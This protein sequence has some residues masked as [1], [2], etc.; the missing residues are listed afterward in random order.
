L[1]RIRLLVLSCISAGLLVASVLPAHATTTWNRNLNVPATA[2]VDVDATACTNHPGP[3]IN[4]SGSLRLGGVSVVLKLDNNRNKPGIFEIQTQPIESSVVVTNLTK[5]TF[6][7]QPP[8]GGVT[9]NPAIYVQ[10]LSGTT[11]VT[12]PVYIGRCVQAAKKHIDASFSSATLLQLFASSLDCNNGGGN[13]ITFGGNFGGSSAVSAVITL[14]GGNGKWTDETVGTVKADLF[15]A[16]GPFSK[17]GSDPNGVTGNPWVSLAA[18][19]NGVV[20][21]FTDPVHCNQL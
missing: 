15:G 7:K 13:Q 16:I 2:S 11:P 4:L 19:V 9:G 8:L 1:K 14:K 3:Y 20:G 18:V 5:K 17:K 10:L 12:D 6:A 21:D